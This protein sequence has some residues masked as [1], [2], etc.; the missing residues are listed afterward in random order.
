M[1]KLMR[2]ALVFALAGATLVGCTKDYS[3]DISDLNKKVSEQTS[4]LS[5]LQTQVSAA[6]NSANE[7]LASAQNALK[8]AQAAAKAAAEANNNEE[9]AALT[10][11]VAT[12]EGTIEDLEARIVALEEAQAKIDEVIEQIKK[13]TKAD[14]DA[15]IAKIK[16]DVAALIESIGVTD[17][18]ILEPEA[19]AVT[20]GQFNGVFSGLKSATWD[21]PRAEEV[22]ALEKGSYISSSNVDYL[23]VQVNPVNADLHD[24]EFTLQNKD[25]VAAPLDFDMPI[26]Y[27]DTKA[28]SGEWY[29]PFAVGEITKAFVAQESNPMTQKWVNAKAS[30][31]YNEAVR[32]N[33]IGVSVAQA[34]KEN[35]SGS[36]YTTDPRG[37]ENILFTPFLTGEFSF[38]ATDP[39][40]VFDAFITK[41]KNTDYEIVKYG[42]KF[43][44]LTVSYDLD[45]VNK[46]FEKN[47]AALNFKFQF[48][49]LNVNGYIKEQKNN[50]DYVNVVIS[51]L[52]APHFA[53]E[54]KAEIADT[55]KHEAAPYRIVY[56]ANTQTVTVDLAK[57]AEQW[58]IAAG[59]DARILWDEEFFQAHKTGVVTKALYYPS[60]DSTVNVDA[61][62]E[63]FVENVSFNS[64]MFK[65]TWNGKATLTFN[66]DYPTFEFD[67]KDVDPVGKTF[68]VTI[69][70]ADDDD[71]YIV[72]VPVEIT[73]PTAAS[74][75]SWY[76]WNDITVYQATAAQQTIS[77]ND[78]LVAKQGFTKT[79]DEFNVAFNTKEVTLMTGAKE[80]WAE[81]QVKGT[82]ALGDNKSYTTLGAYVGVVDDDVASFEYKSQTA[83]A[84]FLVTDAEA[85]AEG[86]AFNFVGS[87]SASFEVEN[88]Y[89][90]AIGGRLYPIENAKVN[91][92][93]RE[94]N[95][96]MTLSKD[97]VLGSSLSA[98]EVLT[99]SEFT[100]FN[101]TTS[102]YGSFTLADKNGKT[103]F[104]N[105]PTKNYGVGIYYAISKVETF[106]QSGNGFSTTPTASSLI[107]VADQAYECNFG[108]DTSADIKDVYGLRVSP[109]K[110]LA[111][112]YGK[113]IQVKITFH[114][115]SGV[116]GSALSYVATKAPY[117]GDQTFTFVVT[118]K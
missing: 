96:S 49:Q 2:I 11:R 35:F 8:E 92:V 50:N 115:N 69:Q 95:T 59:S 88:L 91:F 85:W 44:G 74:I 3:G 55:T 107:N 17:F 81:T 67:G 106:E 20:Y 27:E 7:A 43:D 10:A 56:G 79:A 83:A 25:G 118:I 16:A 18:R 100:P 15:A 104:I 47:D 114:D 110:D 13:D 84:H 33:Y 77:L 73:E 12:I 113:K 5:A 23:T 36:F 31:V 30:L 70:L 28:A 32:S 22:A 45:A 82:D 6:Q 116:V 14:V 64:D 52:N 99:N 111:S 21:G 102:Y 42:I 117:T 87:K 86:T 76:K 26:S 112:Y 60:D 39:E 37:F 80:N 93:V 46:Y 103:L 1:K 78:Y 4:A 57:A 34:K 65:T 38:E 68:Y 48:K 109:A 89:I 53:T 94:S 58:G 98:F 29:V 97:L 40:Y 61:A 71:A 66:K 75:A 105:N 63:L 54:H 62:E 72:T 41:C 51:K 24:V 19:I 101:S 9:V 108:T 90:E